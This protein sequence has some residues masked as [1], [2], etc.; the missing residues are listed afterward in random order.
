VFIYV[1]LNPSPVRARPQVADGGDGRQ[2]SGVAA[3]VLNERWRTAKK[4]WSFTLGIERRG[5]N[6]GAWPA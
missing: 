4:R 1:E 3:N 2:M 6:A 5:D